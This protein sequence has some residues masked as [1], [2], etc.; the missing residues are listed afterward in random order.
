M[1]RTAILTGLILLLA[2]SAF[3]EIDLTVVRD[4]ASALRTELG[5]TTLLSPK[6]AILVA[7]ARDLLSDAIAIIDEGDEKRAARLFGRL[8]RA[9]RRIEAAARKEKSESFDEF[10][11]EWG[12]RLWAASSALYAPDSPVVGDPDENA[13]QRRLSRKLR[14]ASKRATEGNHA[15]AVKRLKSAWGLLLRIDRL[16]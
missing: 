6:A 4:E 12:V 3:G 15:G 10:A 1:L 9:I 13:L 2:G 11:A 8:S 5:A 7:D 14:R 16:P